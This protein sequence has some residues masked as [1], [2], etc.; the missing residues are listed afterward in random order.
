MTP[1]KKSA[2]MTF[3]RADPGKNSKSAAG[4]K[5]GRVWENFLSIKMAI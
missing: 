1:A 2:A 5:F 4:N 3:A